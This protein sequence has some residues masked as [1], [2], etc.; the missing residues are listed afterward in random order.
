M[1]LFFVYLGTCMLFL[2]LLHHWSFTCWYFEFMHWWSICVTLTQLVIWNDCYS[3]FLTEDCFFHMF[4]GINIYCEK[5]KLMFSNDWYFL[6]VF[7]LE[8]I[9]KALES[10]RL[11]NLCISNKVTTECIM[12]HNKMST[13]HITHL[14]NKF[15]SNK[16]I[17]K[18]LWILEYTD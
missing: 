18:K 6:W 16:H 2:K 14:R 17:C 15:Q 8:C 3:Y 13:G 4:T 11:Y 9:F 5:S 10:V 7:I 12:E 1:L